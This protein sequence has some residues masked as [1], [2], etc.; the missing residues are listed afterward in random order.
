MGVDIYETRGHEIACSIALNSLCT[1]LRVLFRDLIQGFEGYEKGF[2][3]RQGIWVWNAWFVHCIF[4][5]IAAAAGF[6]GVRI[7]ERS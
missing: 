1:I 3:K 2:R 5:A 6:S 4:F 7:I